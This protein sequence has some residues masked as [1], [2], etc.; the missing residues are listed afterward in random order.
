MPHNAPQLIPFVTVTN[1]V[2]AARRCGIDIEAIFR[3]E[4]LTPAQLHPSTA[5]IPRATL[6]RVMQRC[7]DDT[8]RQGA[9]QH[10]P[11]ALGE[12]FAFE[13]LADVETFIATSATLRDAARALAWIPPLVNPYLRFDLSEHGHQARITLSFALDD[14]PLDA[15]W[16]FTEAAFTTIIKFSRTL[17]GEEGAV[18]QVSLRH[19]RHAASA[20]CEA[21]FQVPI[22]H[23]APIDALWFDRALLDRPLGG[24]LPAL[25][26][27]AAQRVVEQV[28]QHQVRSLLA[29]DE[30]PA[31]HPLVAQIESACLAKPRL[32]GLGLP[33]LADELGLHV[34]TLQR[35]LKDAGE[36]HS[37]LL[38]RL[39][40]RLARQWLAD[41][42]RSIEDTSERLGFSDRRSFTQAFTRWSG[43]TPTAWRRLHHEVRLQPPV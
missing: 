30:T 13:Y 9:G 5:A 28:A 2:R 36:T 43:H 16:P 26:E 19:A 25:H 35:R 41:P 39:R 1:W 32:L 37:A 3:A 18:G 4:G 24:A 40:F 10:F 33:A 27:M 17:L 42:T 14:A 11:I 20:T 31:S 15:T 7:V 34:R 12:T 8:R 38:D 22:A 23:D 29:S 21:H 6:Q